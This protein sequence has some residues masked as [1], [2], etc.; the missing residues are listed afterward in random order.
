MTAN[1]FSV[2]QPPDVVAAS[3]RSVIYVFY[4]AHVYVVLPIS[5]KD[6]VYLELEIYTQDSSLLQ[7]CTIYYTNDERFFSD[8]GLTLS[9][10]HI[11]RHLPFSFP[12]S[13]GPISK[14]F[15]FMA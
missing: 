8:V 5:L 6:V 15:P 12:N 9:Y 2:I 10:F 7:N 11:G 1:H 4:S 14:N 13:F 3:I